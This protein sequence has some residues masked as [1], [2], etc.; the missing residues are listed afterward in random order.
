MQ[1]HIQRHE[2]LAQAAP[3][4]RPEQVEPLAIAGRPADRDT[5][6]AVGVVLIVGL[7]G[8]AVFGP[9]DPGEGGLD[10]G[11][12][13]LGQAGAGG[14]VSRD[15]G[16]AALQVA[17][18]PDVQGDDRFEAGAGVGVEITPGDE[19]VRQTPGFVAGPGMEGGNE[20]AWSIRPF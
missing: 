11:L 15:C 6:G 19:L 12:T 7:A 8:M 5:A 4:V 18:L 3:G 9:S 2:H 1:L 17:V 20:G 16:Q 13:Q 14:A 10:I